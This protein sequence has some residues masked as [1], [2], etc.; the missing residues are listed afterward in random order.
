[1]QSLFV[2][3]NIYH[4][5][6]K[7][8]NKKYPTYKIINESPDSVLT[9]V[10][11]NEP[12]PFKDTEMRVKYVFSTNAD[13][14]KYVK[15]KE[16]WDKGSIGTSKKL[17]RVETFRG[18]WEFAV[19]SENRVNATNIVQFD[20]KGM[21]KVLVQPMVTKFLKKGLENLRDTTK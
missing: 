20:P 11:H 16:S 18:S 15:W 4:Q 7:K 19:I 9:Y 6:N 1:M 12:F 8:N 17:N 5:A 21:P 3:H 2:E 10:V 13:G 14:S